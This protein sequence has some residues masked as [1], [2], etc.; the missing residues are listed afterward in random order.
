MQIIMKILLLI[1]SC[2]ARALGQFHK[3]GIHMD[4]KGINFITIKGQESW[5]KMHLCKII[6]FNSSFITDNEEIEV[7]KRAVIG[8]GLYMPPE[9]R[10]QLN[11]DYITLTQKVDIYAFG[12]TIYKFLFSPHAE[13]RNLYPE[14]L[15]YFS[16]RLEKLAQACLQHD[17]DYRPTIETVICF[18]AKECN[19]L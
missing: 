16:G 15:N 7:E 19:E 4:V 10:N 18:L 1:C 2:A 14:T 9:I 5:R 6:D 13:L 12:V 3:Y 8:T 17:P 11:N